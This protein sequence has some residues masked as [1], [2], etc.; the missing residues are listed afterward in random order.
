MATDVPPPLPPAPEAPGFRAPPLLRQ[1]PKLARYQLREFRRSRRFL[2]MVGIVL[3]V[4]AILTAVLARY[5]GS[6]VANPVGFYGNGWGSAVGYL[7]VLAAILFGGDAIAGEFQNKTGYFLMGL[8]VRRSTVYFGKLLA[9]YVAAASA[10]LLYLA[11]LVG[12]GVVYFGAGAFPWQLGVSLLLALL[13]LGAVVGVTFVFSSLF[14][15]SAYGFVLTAVLL[16]FG[17]TLIQDYVSVLAHAEPWMVISYASGTVGSVFNAPVNWGLS[18]SWVYMHGEIE[19]NVV[20]KIYT[21]AGVAEGLL[22]MLG[23]LV[24]SAVGGLWLFEREEF[25]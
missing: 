14:K 17:F 10:L 18:G 2:A 3:V 25:T 15:T 7:I 21:V 19:K 8:P 24:A 11:V 5:R 4:G 6:L 9:V 23:Y 12:N 22:I 16:L 13:Y 1:I 20:V